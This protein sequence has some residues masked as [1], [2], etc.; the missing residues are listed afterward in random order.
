VQRTWT[1]VPRKTELSY[2]SEPMRTSSSI[3]PALATVY[4]AGSAV[5]ASGDLLLCMIR[6]V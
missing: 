4:M 5:S 3:A 2:R 6:A 1:E